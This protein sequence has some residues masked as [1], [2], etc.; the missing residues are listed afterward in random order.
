M[1][2][3]IQSDPR[4]GWD[5]GAWPDKFPSTMLPLSAQTRAALHIRLGHRLD[6]C[7]RHH[8]CQC[9]PLFSVGAGPPHVGCVG[10]NA[11]TAQRGLAH[12]LS[13]LSSALFP[14]VGGLASHSRP[15]A[16]PQARPRGRRWR[17][18]RRRRQ[19][20]HLSRP[21]R[22]GRWWGPLPPWPPCPGHAP[23]T[24]RGQCWCSGGGATR[25]AQAGGGPFPRS[26]PPLPPMSVLLPASVG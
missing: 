7:C 11:P 26:R 22:R 4:R 5:L 10:G 21:R 19:R 15:W 24:S 13:S 14:H 8:F 16:L 25:P 20:L 12:H 18:R 9:R 23:A 3:S 2:L 1:L 6:R 17:R